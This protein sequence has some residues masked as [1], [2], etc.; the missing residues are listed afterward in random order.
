MYNL[1]SQIV[2]TH[3]YFN[4]SPPFHLKLR[5]I[6]HHQRG[7]FTPANFTTSKFTQWFHHKRIIFIWSSILQITHFRIE[8]VSSTKLQIFLRISL[9]KII[10]PI[11]VFAFQHQKNRLKYYSWFVF[12][13]GYV[14]NDRKCNLFGLLYGQRSNFATLV[15]LQCL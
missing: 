11:F 2:Q 1:T 13:F 9:N 14:L 8:L 10:A 3:H 12:I 6:L 4:V 7:S 5:V 15:C